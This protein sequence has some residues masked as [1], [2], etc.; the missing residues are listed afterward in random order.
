MSQ[1]TREEG[2]GS[3]GVS[4]PSP[5]NLAPRSCFCSENQ[6]VP[7]WFPGART[8]WRALAVV[9]EGPWAGEPFPTWPRRGCGAAC[10]CGGDRGIRLGKEGRGKEWNWGL[11]GPH[12]QSRIK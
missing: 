2:R 9:G 11:P 3:F 12:H 5:G 7:G 1:R 10:A 6:P 8:G 4:D